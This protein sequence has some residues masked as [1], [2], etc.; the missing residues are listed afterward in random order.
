MGKHS[1]EPAEVYTIVFCCGD[2][3]SM[4]AEVLSDKIPEAVGVE[5]PRCGPPTQG[6]RYAIVGVEM[7][8]VPAEEVPVS[9]RGK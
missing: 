3:G 1:P 6:S 5:C 9:R 4:W 2:C 7:D 8:V